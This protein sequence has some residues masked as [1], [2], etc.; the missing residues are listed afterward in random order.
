MKL[1]KSK[2]VLYYRNVDNKL[3]EY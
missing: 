3:S 1:S 2:N